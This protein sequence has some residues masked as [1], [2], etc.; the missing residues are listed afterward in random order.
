MRW[1]AS[2]DEP[3]FEQRACRP[4]WSGN[5][6]YSNTDQA[7]NNGCGDGN[8]DADPEAGHGNADQHTAAGN[9]D[10]NA[11]HPSR[12]GIAAGDR[13]VPGIPGR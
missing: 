4:V 9:S 11:D 7:T 8:E 2:A 12:F 13:R 3:H 5:G 6:P 1:R 10:A